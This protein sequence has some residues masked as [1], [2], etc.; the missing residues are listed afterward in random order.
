M[1]IYRLENYTFLEF[2]S[3]GIKRDGLFMAK[4]M[5]NFSSHFQLGTFYSCSNP[6]LKENNK[7]EIIGTVSIPMDQMD[8]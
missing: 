3:Y 8:L 1:I 7:L 2:V 5:P 4:F 6:S